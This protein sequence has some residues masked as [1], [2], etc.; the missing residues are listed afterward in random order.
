LEIAFFLLSVA[1][2]RHLRQVSLQLVKYLPIR[3]IAHLVVL[4]NYEALLVAY[5][6]FPFGHHSV[7]GMVLLADFRTTVS[8]IA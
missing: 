4:P 8:I 2:E 3:D 5:S 1:G 7:A 6:S